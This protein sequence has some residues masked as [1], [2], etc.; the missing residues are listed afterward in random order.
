[1]RR[2]AVLALAGAV[3][4]LVTAGSAQ[5]HTR[6]YFNSLSLAFHDRPAGDAFDGRVSSAK[7]TCERGR[8]VVV[9]RIQP[10]SYARIGADVSGSDGKWVV[11]PRGKSVPPGR[12]YATMARK[13][14]A[15]SSAHH[16]SCSAVTTPPI[17][18]SS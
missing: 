9:W 10:G 15:R 11:D 14:L 13:V 2:A 7:P 5:A 18:I 16:H 6:A 12:Y 17:T 1:M 3:L 8:K 4:G